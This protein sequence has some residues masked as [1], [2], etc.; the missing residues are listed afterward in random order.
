VYND[1]KAFRLAILKMKGYASLWYEP[2]KKNRVREAK[3]KI[4]AL[5]KLMKYME[6]IFLSY[7][8][9]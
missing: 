5:S 6:K 2:L 1:E 4:K 7:L 3:S 9:K 8:H